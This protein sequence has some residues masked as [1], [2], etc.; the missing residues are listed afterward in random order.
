MRTEKRSIHIIR[1]KQEASESWI[2]EVALDEPV[3]IFVNGDY[4]ATLIATPDQKRE[5]ALGYLLTGGVITSIQ[6]V[7]SIGFRGGDIF[8]DLW[9]EVDLREASINIMNLIVTSCGS[10]VEAKP[11]KLHR[12][13]SELTIKAEILLKMFAV[14]NKRSR[15]HMRTRGTHSALL[16]SG[17]G[18]I[19]AF[20][21]DVGRHNAVDK[22]IGSMLMKGRCLSN[23]VL[24][25][26]GR[27]SGE[28]VQKAV[29]GR[30]PIV[31]SLTVPL[32][33]GIRMAESAGVTLA[34]L[35]RG[36]LKVYSNPER[37]RINKG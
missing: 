37:I 17:A 10:R 36:W 5:L 34:S 15:I 35:S 19:Q 23:C 25:T 3:C 27:L 2:E 16:C 7:K 28:I 22:V 26:S 11:L 24:V 18:E 9:R 32:A 33:S 30:V 29:M 31:A 20:A 1:F 14:V 8:V 6:E 21:E 4:H 13:E 12:I